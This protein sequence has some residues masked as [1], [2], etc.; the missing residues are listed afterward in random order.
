MDDNVMH[1]YTKTASEPRHFVQ[2]DQGEDRWLSTLLL[3]QGYR[4]EYAAAADA[5]TYAPEGFDEFFNQRRRWTPSSIANTL[6]LL[7]DYKLASKNNR[8]ISKLYI[9]YQTIV[10]GFYLLGPAIIFTMLVYA[11]VAAFAMDSL[12]VLVYNA[13]PV[14]LFVLSCFCLESGVQLLFAKIASILYAFIMMAVLIA[15]MQQIVLETIFSPTSAFVLAMA[16]IFLSASFVHPKEFTNIIYGAV[17]FLMI[18]ATYVFMSLYSLINL[19]VINWGTREAIAKATGRVNTKEGITQRL[20]KR[21]RDPNYHSS[22][23]ARFLTKH[24]DNEDSSVGMRDLEKGYEQTDQTIRSLQKCPSEAE[25]GNATTP[26]TDI[27]QREALEQ[28]TKTIGYMNDVQQTT[29]FDRS[30]WM[31]C[32]YLQNCNRGKLQL[33]EEN[34][35]DELIDAYLKPIETTVEEELTIAK[36]LATLRNRISFSILLLNAL[37]VLAVFLLQRHK[38]VLSIQLTPYEGFVW[39]KLN[40]T[41]GKFEHTTEALKVDPLGM[42]II[43]FLMGILVVQTIGMLIHRLNT[44]VEALH[45][46][47]ELGDQCSSYN[48]AENFKGYQNV[49]DEARQMIDT[50]S[51]DR[52]HGADGYVRS[53]LAESSSSRNVLYKLEQIRNQ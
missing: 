22:T 30:L 32:E 45:E 11:Q 49:L 17:F 35:W 25:K 6:D 9:L 48:N 3:K 12:R 44:L 34:F 50:A 42:G 19:N 16:L 38:D 14:C 23:I 28:E 2:Y 13:V 33:D 24:G 20:W 39:T 41:T 8:S 52:A 40:E 7:A 29:A 26:V 4:I 47:N 27:N 21:V 5:E 46:L 37:L 15:T 43:F 51:Y 1:K 31:D 10:T 36:G 53:G 18:P